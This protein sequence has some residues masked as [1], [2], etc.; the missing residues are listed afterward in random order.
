MTIRISTDGKDLLQAIADKAVVTF[1]DVVLRA[2]R[3]FIE[4][5]PIPAKAKSKK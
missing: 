1:S 5:N 2:V 3:D 4:S